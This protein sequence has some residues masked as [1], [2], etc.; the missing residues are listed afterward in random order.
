MG[1]EEREQEA[2]L[3]RGNG[4]GHIS[5]PTGILS[6]WP[7]AALL[8]AVLPE[9]VGMRLPR[10]CQLWLGLAKEGKVE[11]RSGEAPVASCLMHHRNQAPMKGHV[12]SFSRADVQVPV[13]QECSRHRCLPGTGCGDGRE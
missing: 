11:Q 12:L 7:R 8:I 2:T 6:P 1:G 5:R 4:P 10:E 13:A 3:R 9:L